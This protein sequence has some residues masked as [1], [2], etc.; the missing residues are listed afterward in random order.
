MEIALKHYTVPSLIETLELFEEGLALCSENIQ[1]KVESI[2]KKH[3]KNLLLKDLIKKYGKIKQIDED[4]IIDLFLFEYDTKNK[5][6][7]TGI[8][9]KARKE[10]LKTISPYEIL[11]LESANKNFPVFY[12]TIGIKQKERFL[13]ILYKIYSLQDFDNNDHFFKLI[14]DEK[15]YSLSDKGFNDVFSAIDE[16]VAKVTPKIMKKILHDY[17]EQKN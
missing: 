15:W 5:P 8:Y 13:K 12:A 4:N 11:C 17:K 10:L 6:Y 9:L 2:I 7:L 14:S 1:N 16:N 3:N